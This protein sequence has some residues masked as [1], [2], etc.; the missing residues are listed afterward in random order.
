[1]GNHTSHTGNFATIIQRLYNKY[2]KAKRFP[3]HAVSF[4]KVNLDRC[5]T[6]PA[7][8]EGQRSAPVAS[9][10]RVTS[11]TCRTR[12]NR[13][14]YVNRGRARI[15]RAT[16]SGNTSALYTPGILKSFD[17]DDRVD[18]RAG[19]PSPCERC[20]RERG[21]CASARRSIIKAT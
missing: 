13:Y 3:R 12:I 17:S 11:I 4:S 20:T 10:S 16:Q 6:V 8:F 19:V 21:S 7:L 1:M 18:R 14:S 2:T 5:T 15:S 9:S